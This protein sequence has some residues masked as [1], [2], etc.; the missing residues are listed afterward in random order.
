MGAFREIAATKSEMNEIMLTVKEQYNGQLEK[1]SVLAYDYLEKIDNVAN[2]ENLM[3][4]EFAKQS[5][6][7]DQLRQVTNRQ[8]EH[9][10]AQNALI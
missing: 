9:I 6:T 5:Y 4:D 1:F 3:R 2:R 7:L 8:K 10:L